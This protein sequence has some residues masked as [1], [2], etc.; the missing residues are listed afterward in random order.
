MVLKFHIADLFSI[1]S[2]LGILS[3]NLSLPCSLFNK[4]CMLT[5]EM[6]EQ[7][8]QYL[9]AVLQELVDKKE[10]C[11]RDIERMEYEE[12]KYKEK[13]NCGN[14]QSDEYVQ[15]VNDLHDEIVQALG[16]LY[17]HRDQLKMQIAKAEADLSRL[18]GYL[19]QLEQ[20][21]SFS[22]QLTAKGLDI[23]ERFDTFSR[24]LRSYGDSAE[25]AK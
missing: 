1:S 5:V 4:E 7:A 21:S 2:D 11:D 13:C 19:R 15:K 17:L 23:I 16:A 3:Q 10:A 9:E 22:D 25:A 24:M 20:I 8:K 14:T 6:A 18:N 12:N